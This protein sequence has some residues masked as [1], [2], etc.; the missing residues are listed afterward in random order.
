MAD[1]DDK[2]RGKV[3]VFGKNVFSAP[4]LDT[5]E[6]STIVIRRSTGEPMAFFTRLVD[7]T[8]AFANESDSDW[9]DSKLRFGVS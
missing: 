3:T 7:D 4:L 2:Y 9:Q 5:S 8:W 6:A 1:K